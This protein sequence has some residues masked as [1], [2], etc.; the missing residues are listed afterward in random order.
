M[1]GWRISQ[2][3]VQEMSYNSSKNLNKEYKK[4]KIVS[5]LEEEQSKCK[6][7]LM[8]IAWQMTLTHI[9]YPNSFGM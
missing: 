1:C 5:L 7:H 2:L 4:A 3:Q 9:G 6:M 8:K